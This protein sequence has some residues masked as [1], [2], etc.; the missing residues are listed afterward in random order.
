[1][2]V[3]KFPGLFVADHADPVIPAFYL[4]LQILTWASTSNPFLQL[5]SFQRMIS[6][7]HRTKRQPLIS[8]L[9]W[10]CQHSTILQAYRA[11]FGSKSGSLR[12]GRHT[13]T[14]VYTNLL[15]FVMK[16]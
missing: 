14:G 16:T 3:L 10:R 13:T 6:D 1:M 9:K 7:Q 4:L 15:S 11:N 12:F 2:T 8:L 5:F